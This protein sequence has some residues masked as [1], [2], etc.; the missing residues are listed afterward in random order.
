MPGKT[1]RHKKTTMDLLIRLRDKCKELY[2]DYDIVIRPVLKFGLALMVFMI[3]NSELGYLSALNN[4]F[5]LIILAVICAILPLNGIV[6]IGTLL[7]VA[8]CFGLGMEVGGFAAI[9]YLLMLLLYFRYAPSCCT[10]CT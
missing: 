9:L 5:V 7:I 10:R 8:H 6:V 3:I 4:L 2:A 1:R